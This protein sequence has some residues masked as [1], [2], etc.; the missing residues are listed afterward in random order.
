MF[1]RC[2]LL[3]ALL[4]LYLIGAND[5]FGHKHGQG[6]HRI[7]AVKRAAN[8][9]S[10]SISS[11]ATTAASTSIHNIFSI[12]TR[13]T[14]TG[15]SSSITKASTSIHENSSIT[16]Q[17]TEI[18]LSSTITTA[19]SSI[20]HISSITSQSIKTTTRSALSSIPSADHEAVG[21]ITTGARSNRSAIRIEVES[22]RKLGPFNVTE[23]CVLWNSACKGN[24]TLA[25][26]RFFGD[27]LPRL[28][29]DDCFVHQGEKCTNGSSA[30][31]PWQFE[32]IK[33]FMR[34]SECGASLAKYDGRHNLTKWTIEN[35]HNCCGQCMIEAQ[36][37]FIHYWP[38]ANANE[39]CKSIV[40]D[41]IPFGLYHGATTNANGQAYW[42]CTSG[43]ETITT[44]QITT[45]GMGPL[46]VKETI[47]DPWG[48]QPCTEAPS[49]DPSELSTSF[50]ADVVPL[51][52]QQSITESAQL[53]VST[54]VYR[55][56]TL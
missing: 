26:E 6:H 40:G 22:A 48:P 46:S 50:Y 5:V 42:G 14:Q 1:T 54:V 12:T 25:T 49:A 13:S 8:I 38:E 19:S 30:K 27:L 9:V 4:F 36:N 53:P 51:S 20:H 52:I 39:S 18:N 37:V 32:E 10:A 16:S 44:A 55:N 43:S 3:P 11:S 2:F 41:G 35:G 21:D 15:L 23:E 28:L 7:P 24:K 29:E 45:L 31:N 33:K 17:S 34:S 47:V 56:Y